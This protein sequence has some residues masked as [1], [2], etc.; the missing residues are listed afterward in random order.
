M[1]VDW[2]NYLAL[3]IQAGASAE[4]AQREVDAARAERSAVESGKCPRCHSA[5]TPRQ[6]PRQHGP[7]SMQG[8]WHQVR[9]SNCRYMADFVMIDKYATN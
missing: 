9:C 2:D 5:I 4:D 1:N 3:L 8:T 7:T 6:D